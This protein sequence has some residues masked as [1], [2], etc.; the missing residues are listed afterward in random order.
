MTKSS[1]RP[2]SKYTPRSSS[3]W[4][5][6]TDISLEIIMFII[7]ETEI[8]TETSYLFILS[9]LRR[10]FRVCQVKSLMYGWGWCS[11]AVDHPGLQSWTMVSDLS[12]IL[13]HFNSLIDHNDHQSH[14][15]AG[16]QGQVE[17]YC[18]QSRYD[19]DLWSPHPFLPHLSTQRLGVKEAPI[20]CLSWYPVVST[21]WFEKF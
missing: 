2:S 20:T 9:F 6:D 3:G 16:R 8:T 12:S 19:G 15:E 13:S 1:N 7:I 17:I 10:K 21:K 11:D 4:S 14:T 5:L 18:L